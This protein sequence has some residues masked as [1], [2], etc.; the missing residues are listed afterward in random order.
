VIHGVSYSRERDVSV[1]TPVSESETMCVL[2][3]EQLCF[4]KIRLENLSNYCRIYLDGKFPAAQN[5]TSVTRH[6]RWAT[7]NRGLLAGSNYGGDSSPEP[8]G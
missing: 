4:K 7:K 6:E 2:Q 3:V 1:D 5:G 8:L